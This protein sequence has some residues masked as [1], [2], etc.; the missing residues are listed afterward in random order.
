MKG[1]DSKGIFSE[2]MKSV[3]N[4]SSECRRDPFSVK[5]SSE[6]LITIQI[7]RGLDYHHERDQIEAEKFVQVVGPSMK[8][9]DVSIV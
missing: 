1:I 8:Q 3:K 6:C 4:R 7:K 9:P 5:I 2:V